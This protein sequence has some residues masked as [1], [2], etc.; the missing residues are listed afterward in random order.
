MADWLPIYLK[1][2][3]LI[4]D[5]VK[6]GKMWRT[7]ADEAPVL[8]TEVDLTIGQL[9]FPRRVGAPI[10]R[11]PGAIHQTTASEPS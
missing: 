4:G 8:L 10:P 9:Q 5:I 1:G 11:G 7:G 3:K 6:Y 2:R